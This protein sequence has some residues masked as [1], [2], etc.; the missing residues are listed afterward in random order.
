MVCFNELRI[1]RPKTQYWGQNPC[2]R[3]PYKGVSITD[4]VSVRKYFVCCLSGVFVHIKTNGV[5]AEFIFFFRNEIKRG[6]G[7]TCFKINA[8]R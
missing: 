8:S 4:G 5:V 1:K 7:Q 3:S 6:S 2:E